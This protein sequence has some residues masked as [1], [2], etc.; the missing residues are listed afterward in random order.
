MEIVNAPT[1]S[2]CGGLSTNPAATQCQYCGNA[3][4]G[5]GSPGAGYAQPPQ[6]YGQQQPYGAPPAGYGQA[7]YGQPPG[8]Y[9]GYPQA[10]PYGQPPAPYGQQGYGYGAP[11]VQ[12]FGGGYAPSHPRSGGF[13]SGDGWSL[14]WKIRLI[15]A[16]CA[17]AIFGLA[18]CVSAIAN[19]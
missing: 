10:N 14:Y 6:P 9:G 15:I 19:H 16:L 1:C 17:F 7:P 11:P 13:W 18:T 12:P 3:L 5:Y 2:R 4:G 8:G